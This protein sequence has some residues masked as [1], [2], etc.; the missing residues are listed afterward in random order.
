[1]R[2][3]WLFGASDSAS[4]TAELIIEDSELAP[5]VGRGGRKTVMNNRVSQGAL[6]VNSGSSCLVRHIFRL[7]AAMR[8]A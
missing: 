5:V 8:F 4:A 2:R 6:R 7:G 3:L 1:M